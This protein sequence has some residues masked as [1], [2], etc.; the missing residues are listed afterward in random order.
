MKKLETIS[1]EEERSRG[2]YCWMAALCSFFD[3][4]VPTR[5]RR[6]IFFKGGKERKFL[7]L[8]STVMLF[9]GTWFP[10][11]GA[12]V[13][14]VNASRPAW[15]QEKLSFGIEARIRYE[16][17]DNFNITGYGE[18]VPAGKDNDSI[19]LGRVRMGADYTPSD[20]IRFSLWGYQAN[21]WDF[22]VP[23]QAFYNSTFGME[24]G[25]YEDRTE[26]YRG[27]VEFR[28][29][30]GPRLKLK[31]GRQRLDYGDFR[32]FGLC[33]WTN[34][35]PYLWDAVKIAYDFSKDNFIDAFYGRIKINDPK[36]FSLNHRHSYTGAG[37]YSRFAL[38]VLH[39]HLEPFFAYK[40]D[41]TAKYQGEDGRP[42]DLDE[43]YAG[44]RIWGRNFYHFDYDLW[45]S[46][47]FGQRGNDDIGAYAFHVL[48][49]YNLAD[50]WT[51]PRLSVEYTYS[52]GDDNPDDGDHGTFDVGYGVWGA[53]YGNQ[54]SFFKWRN[55]QDLQVNL[56][57]WPTKG[58]KTILGL[59]NYWLAEEKDAWYLNSSLYRDPD[60]NAGRHVGETLEGTIS[61]D[62]YTV[63]AHDFFKGQH[64]SATC[65][66]FF[67]GEVPHRLAHETTGANWFYL[68]WSYKGAWVVF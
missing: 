66:H 9:I 51:Q 64:V 63:F 7:F 54:W 1:M 21:A 12:E 36:N 61:I 59:H 40:G 39:A 30:S 10:A 31:L 60:G 24:D 29:T 43:Y 6:I 13:V 42:G 5:N 38:P 55:F 67:D 22:S 26:L 27:F 19:Y 56:E 34:T 47:E 3:D 33:N 4:L 28:T 49:G 35:G 15:P 32:T 62:L 46:R 37:M 23:R 65:G 11:H 14:F 8:I 25:P 45:F 44:A 52:S 18:N 16:N 2:M 41:N 20:K 17:L 68:Q 50:L 53:W 58:I 57:L 48:L